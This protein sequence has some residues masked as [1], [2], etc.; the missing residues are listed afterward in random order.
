[1]SEANRVLVG[2]FI[3]ETHETL[4]RLWARWQDEKQYEDINDYG[5]VIAKKFP[6][7][8]KLLKTT[9]RPFGV[10]VLIGSEKW[11]IRVTG[12]QI[13]WKMAK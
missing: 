6:E 9:K 11:Q 4:G 13:T 12:K 7:G 1:M 10:D 3:E 8:W 5:A 2:K